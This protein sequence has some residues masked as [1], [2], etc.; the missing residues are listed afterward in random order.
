M[1]VFFLHLFASV[2][3]RLDEADGIA[4]NGSTISMSAILADSIPM[5]GRKLP[6]LADAIP[7]MDGKWKI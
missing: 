7:S 2:Q 5:A 6:C 1:D 3:K 4:S